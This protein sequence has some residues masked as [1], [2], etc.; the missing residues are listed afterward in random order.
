MTKGEIR[1]GLDI[2]TTK[3]AAVIAR[4]EDDGTPAIIG[5]GTSPCEGLRRGVVINLE[6]TVE[7]ITKAV[8]DAERMAGVEIREAY[9]GIAGDYIKSLNSRGVIA[10]LR[11]FVIF[12]RSS[13]NIFLPGWII[14]F[15]IIFSLTR[16]AV[17]STTTF[18]ILKTGWDMSLFTTG[19]PA[20][21][22][23]TAMSITPM[24]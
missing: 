15:S 2:G 22:S 17:P 4:G 8:A 16:Y 12:S 13:S 24:R 23:T 21:R 14:A 9:V 10:V 7:G 1:V 11:V 3:I 19:M 6:K 20:K 18:R 5:V